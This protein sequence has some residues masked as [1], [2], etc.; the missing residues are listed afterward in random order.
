MTYNSPQT[1]DREIVIT[2]LL[3]APRELVFDLWTDPNHL[4]RWWGPRGFSVTT[5]ELKATPGGRWKFTMLGPDGSSY[6]GTLLFSE[7]IRPQRLRF[8]HQLCESDVTVTFEP[9]GE[10]TRLTMH[11]VFASPEQR[12][13]KAKMGVTEGGN[14]TFDRLEEELAF[15]EP[16]QHPFEITRTFEASRELVFQIWTQPEHLRHWWGPKGCKIEVY[17]LDLQPGGIFHYSMQMP[18]G[19]KMWAKFIYREIQ[20]PKRLVFLN[21]FANAEA[22]TIPV[23]FSDTW[24]RET[25]SVITFE[26]NGKGTSVRIRTAPLNATAVEKQTFVD[27]HASMTNGW[28]GTLDQLGEYLNSP[29]A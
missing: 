17:R 5:Q 19:G 26:E 1:A 29:R 21:C 27:G 20:P 9:E 25:L 18:D 24:P 13:E 12:D 3:N 23:P 16:G 4:G 8:D 15:L 10:K 11:M 6:E 2:R 28:G 22:E 14:Q 7:V